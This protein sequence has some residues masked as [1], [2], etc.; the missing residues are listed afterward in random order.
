MKILQLTKKF[1]F[2][3]KDGE[4]IAV[5][6]LSQSLNELGVE[7]TLLSMNTVKHYVDVDGLPESFNHYEE[8]HSVELDNRVTVLGA[9]QNLFSKESYHVS[10]FYFKRYKEKLIAL[11]KANSFDIVLLE[12]L[13]LAPYIDEIRIHSSAKIV[14]RSH[15]VEYEIWNRITNNTSFI[16]KRLYLFYLTQKL[17][18][19]ELRALPNYDALVTVTHRDLESYTKIG[20]SRKGFVLPISINCK[21][22]IPK[23]LSKNQTSL[24]FIGSLDWMPN[25][26]GLEWFLSKVWPSVINSHPNIKLHIAGRNTPNSIVALA[27]KNIIIEGEVEDAKAFINEHSIMIVPLLSGSGMRVKILEGMALGRVVVSTSIGMEGINAKHTNEIMCADTPQEF[28]D[29]LSNMLENME[30]QSQMGQNARSFIEQNFDKQF[31][32]KRFV[33]FLNNEVLN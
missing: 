5:T 21:D 6:N 15:N 27:S 28:H 16:P 18:N 12:T 13:Y 20:F 23:K 19:F 24:S 1:P 26:E 25:L 29:A 11:L 31:N 7:I 30:D 10:R 8:I 9:I 2:P 17:K 22:Y 14:M 33:S 3:L 4:S 32:A